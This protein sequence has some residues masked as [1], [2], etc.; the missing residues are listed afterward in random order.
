MVKPALLYGCEIWVTR[1][2]DKNKTQV[3]EVEFL[4]KVKG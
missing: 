2:R 3:I 4:L 1:Q